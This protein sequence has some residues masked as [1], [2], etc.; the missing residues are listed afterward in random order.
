MN[1]EKQIQKL[2][3]IAK[4]KKASDITRFNMPPHTSLADTMLVISAKNSLQLGAIAQGLKKEVRD[5]HARVN[6]SEA[7]GWIVFDLGDVWV[8]VVTSEIRSY[9]DLD[10]LFSESAQ[11]VVHE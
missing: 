9:Y 8:H 2:I 10:A 3:E 7:S 6:G 5:S 4:D 1:T 11:E